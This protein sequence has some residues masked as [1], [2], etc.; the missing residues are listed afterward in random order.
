MADRAGWSATHLGPEGYRQWRASTLGR[1]TERLEQN[2][3]LELLGNLRG[4]KVLE[5]GSG[6]GTLAVTLAERGASIVGLDASRP[7]L[8][9]AAARVTMANADV[10]LC[11]GLAEAL[12]F[13]DDA[14]DAVVA[15]T[16]LCFVDDAEGTFKEIGRVLR[17]G[18]R[19]VIGELGR[20][21]TWAA[22][23]RTRG[24]LG[25]RLWRHGHFRTAGE[26]RRLA[27]AAGLE[28]RLVR[29]AVYYPRATMAARCLSGVDRLLGRLTTI[30]GAFI[31][32]LAEKPKQGACGK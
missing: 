22:A 16:I 3:V 15:V 7:M 9:A 8:D 20:W 24:W 5:I 25:S 12:P 32:M 31:A 4:Q 28:S 19:L 27:A 18:G 29:G 10:A 26:L 1:I 21:S 17:P 2:L 23:R 6:D 11:R 14:F 30:G 13:A